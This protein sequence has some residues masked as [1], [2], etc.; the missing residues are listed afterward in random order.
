[1]AHFGE[2]VFDRM[3]RAVDKVEERARRSTSALAE[4]GIDYALGGSNATKVWIASFDESAIRYAR[5]VELVLLRADLE[6]AARVL[7]KVGFVLTDD[8][9][10]IRFLDGPDGK[11][12]DA[13]EITFGGE[14]ARGKSPMVTAPLPTDSELVGGQRVL[15]LDRLVEFQL[16]RYRLDDA[17]DARD[18]ID[19]GL[20]DASWPAKFRPELASLL[21]HLLDTPDG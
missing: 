16:A 2:D 1:V 21:Q 9:G 19:V 3:I 13:V 5:N 14:P 8:R 20:V 12:R 17:V 15:R 7:T 11:I 18:L 6:R 4:A 10:R